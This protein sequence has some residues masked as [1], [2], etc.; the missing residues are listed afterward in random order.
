MIK[1]NYNSDFKLTEKTE[2]GFAGVSFAF[3]YTTNSGTYT[4]SYDGTTYTNC[5]RNEDGSVTVIFNHHGLGPGRLKV[6]RE[7]FVPDGDFPDGV[8]NTV[9]NDITDVMLVEGKTEGFD[10]EETFRPPYVVEGGGG[11]V[12]VEI[13]DSLDSDASDKALSARQGKVLKGMIPT[14]VSELENDEGYI[15]EIP[16]EYATKE[17]V[18]TAIENN[19]EVFAAIY[20]K[21]TYNEILEAYNAG[22]AIVCNGTSSVYVL[23]FVQKEAFHFASHYSEFYYT[24]TCTS[25]N[26]WHSRSMGVGNSLTPN[27]DKTATINIA[28]KSAIVPTKE[29]IDNLIINTLNTEV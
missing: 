26:T 28:G 1:I 20:G 2:E 17:D 15:T 5:K 22:K 14:K 18:N 16:E 10:V 29:Y 21:T 7:F 8:Y 9:S 4:A 13:V 25:S 19:K 3:V 24:A 6:R 27:D 12:S 11:I 23:S